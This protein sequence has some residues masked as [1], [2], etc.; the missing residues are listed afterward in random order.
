MVHPFDHP[1]PKDQLLLGLSA[2][3]WYAGFLAN[4]WRLKRTSSL[5]R[6]V[7]IGAT[8]LLAGLAPQI[9]GIWVVLIYA[10]I[11]AA[12]AGVSWHS[13]KASGAGDALGLRAS[14]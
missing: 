9:P 14:G 6:W 11:I 7:A 8:W 13:L 5:H 4:E 2:T 3:L 10:V 12:T 1:G